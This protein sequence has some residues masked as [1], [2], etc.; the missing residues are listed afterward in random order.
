MKT[1]FFL[2][3]FICYSHLGAQTSDTLRKELLLVDFYLSNSDNVDDLRGVYFYY[4]NDSLV[5]Q[6]I[7]QWTNEQIKETPLFVLTKQTQIKV[8]NELYE[9]G[10]RLIFYNSDSNSYFFERTKIS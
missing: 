3:A 8:L 6:P 1:I 2:L 7:V 9:Q 10:W 5:F 4:P